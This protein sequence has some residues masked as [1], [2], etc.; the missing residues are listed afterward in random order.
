MP[1]GM[2]VGIASVTIQSSGSPPIT[3]STEVLA[4]APALFTADGTGKGPPAATAIQIIA[5][6]TVP[7]AVFTCTGSACFTV[8]IQLGLDTPTYLSLYGSGIRHRSSL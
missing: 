5:G 1:E 7:V 2:A 8:P 6:R 4:V 3:A